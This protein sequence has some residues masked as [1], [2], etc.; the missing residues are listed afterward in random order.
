MIWERLGLQCSDRGLGTNKL[1]ACS[2]I[3]RKIEYLILRP[4]IKLQNSTEC[5]IALRRNNKTKVTKQAMQK[6]TDM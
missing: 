4:I 2:F 3:I 1:G 5:E 6:Q